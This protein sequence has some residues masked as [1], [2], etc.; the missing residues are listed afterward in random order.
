MPGVKS[1]LPMTT[2]AQPMPFYDYKPSE[3]SFLRNRRFP[4]PHRIAGCLTETN[5]NDICLDARARL[6]WICV[7]PSESRYLLAIIS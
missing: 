4:A 2:Q 1:G 5:L 7:L 3:V 6:D